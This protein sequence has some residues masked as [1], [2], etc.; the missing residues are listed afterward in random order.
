MSDMT[1]KLALLREH[2]ALARLRMA[3][4]DEMQRIEMLL[5]PQD[6]ID[7]LAAARAVYEMKLLN[8]IDTFRW[9]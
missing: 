7:M 3:T 4:L 1:E 2:E 9:V 8:N 5:V 6:E